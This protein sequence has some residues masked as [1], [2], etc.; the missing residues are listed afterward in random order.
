MN[1]YNI[2]KYI[3]LINN[4]ICT[5]RIFIILLILRKNEEGFV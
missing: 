2:F 4:M 1:L 3:Y 5:F